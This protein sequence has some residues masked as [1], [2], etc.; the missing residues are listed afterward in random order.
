MAKSIADCFALN[1]FADSVKSAAMADVDFFV[2][3]D[4]RVE[5]IV[6][7]IFFALF[8]L[9]VMQ[10]RVPM[11]AFR[12]YVCVSRVGVR[13]LSVHFASGLELF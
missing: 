6:S 4:L 8:N 12:C 10:D 9:L 2:Q 13:V 5:N 11:F 3:I 7:V 1:A